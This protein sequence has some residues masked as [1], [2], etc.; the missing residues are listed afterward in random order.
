MTPVLS[1]TI[2]HTEIIEHIH[3]YTYGKVNIH[4]IG[5]KYSIM[6]NLSLGDGIEVFSFIYFEI[7]QIF[8]N[9]YVL[10]FN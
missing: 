10:L 3:A 1:K 5:K 4:H 6:D 2:T 9:K 7:F 8:K